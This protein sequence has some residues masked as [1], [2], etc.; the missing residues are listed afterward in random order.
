VGRKIVGIVSDTLGYDPFHPRTFSG[1]S[2]FFFR[3]LERRAMLHRAFGVGTSQLQRYTYLMRNFHFKYAT[4]RTRF[5]MDVS[6][7]NLLTKQIRKSLTEQDLH[8]DILQLGSYYDA[9]QAVD[10]RSRCFSYHDANF[11]M[12]LKS[13]SKATLGLGAGRVDKIIAYER[14]VNAGMTRVFTFSQYLRNSFIVDYGLNPASVVTIG[15]GINLERIPGYLPNKRY[16]S[17]ELLFVGIEFERKG[18]WQLL[19]AFAGVRARFPS[20]ILHI[21]GPRTLDVPSRWRHGVQY[22]GFLSKKIPSEFQK[23]NELTQRSCLFVLPSLYDPMA[24][25]PLEAML[26]QLPAVLTN[27]W[28]FPEMVT[29]GKNGE[30][31]EC[32][33]V[34]DLEAK[35]T[36]LLGD[37]ERLR[38]MGECARSQVIEKF[39]WDKVVQRLESAIAGVS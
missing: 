10:G 4:W 36:S 22:H 30:L 12:S 21:V 18:G 31:V 25:A 38:A 27:D 8:H 20:A 6:R 33:S 1:A 29:P 15:T 7:R 17:Q 24:N 2:A 3:G 37:P 28:G 9:V 39:G 19:E 26:Q 11:A 16:D 13:P 35:L 32:L 5:S 23:L 34:M 14:R